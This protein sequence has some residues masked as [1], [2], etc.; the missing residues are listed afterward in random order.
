MEWFILALVASIFWA[1]VV[2]VDKFILTRYIRDAVAY[3]VFLAIVMLPFIA[4]LLPFTPASINGNGD[5][6]LNPNLNLVL[7]PLTILLGVVLGLGFVLYNRALLIEE[8]SRVTP[9]LF[10]SPLFVLLLSYLF[11]GEALPMHRYVGIGLM[12]LS[13]ITVSLRVEGIRRGHG[14]S[15]SHSMHV[16]LSPALLMILALDMMTATKDVISKLLLAHLD[17]LSYLFWFMLGNIIGRPLLLL[18]PLNRSNTLRV[19]RTLPLKIYLLCFFNSSLGWA[20][21]ILYFKAISMTYVSLVSAIPT[22]QPFIVFVFATLLG[23]FY[24]ELIEEKIDRWSVSLKGMAVLS[25]LA[26]T[27][28]ILS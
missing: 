10:L 16:T 7:I 21:Y 18:M 23:F 9:L 11:I 2:I 24:P 5:G 4:F 14:H 20:G 3:Q 28:L 25:I 1:V 13:A 15:H 22:T 19:V 17:Y 26:G 8:V 27:Y 6:N 12:V